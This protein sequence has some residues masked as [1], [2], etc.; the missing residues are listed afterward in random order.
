MWARVRVRARARCRPGIRLALATW[1]LRLLSLSLSLL[2]L[3][4][5]S[6]ACDRVASITSSIG[7]TGASSGGTTSAPSIDPTL[8]R[9]D[10]D[11]V[12]VPEASPVRSRLLVA[13]AESKSIQ[14]RLVV[15][16]SVESDP[17]R[18]AKITPPLPG[19]VVKLFVRF[20][21]TV[22]KEQP[23]LAMDSPDLVSAQT[24]Y[25]RAKSA[26]VQAERTLARQK[27]LQQHGIGAQ[28]ELEQ[29]DTEAAVASSELERAAV[30]L[31]LLGSDP[32]QLGKQLIV[33]SPIAGRIV[34]S[35]VAPGEFHNDQNAVLMTIAD[36][37]SVWVTA[38]VQEKDIRRVR[39]GQ[40]AVALFVAYPGEKLV[41]HVL[42][43]GDLL[44]PDTRTIKVR[45]AFDNRDSRL[46]PGM[47]ATMT[48]TSAPLPE[49]VVRTTALVLQGDHSYVFAELAV[50]WTFERR[51]I[52][53]GETQGE[54]AVITKGLE[55]GTRVVMRDAVLLQ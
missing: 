50:P 45:V 12:F 33:R 51:P 21:D 55:A 5:L 2:P 43:V 46:K 36:L 15:P 9:R 22:A 19:R 53:V 39:Q 31:R 6:P 38:H 20:G 7:A 34:E 41:G 52:E 14:T 35:A 28:K 17:A 42:F 37:S 11:R 27:D 4:M 47:F 24:D 13:P 26:E 48:F 18:T 49:V 25:L 30:R 32:G 40:E 44:D 16:A 8:L 3:S 29:A 10:G 23:L 1:S 54:L